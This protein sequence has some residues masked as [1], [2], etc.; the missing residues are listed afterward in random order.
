MIEIEVKAKIDDFDKI[1]QLVQKKCSFIK[2]FNKNDLY[3]CNKE[4]L[5]F[6]LRTLISVDDKQY[7]ITTKEKALENRVEINKETE[8]KID[9]ESQFL[10]FAQLIGFSQTVR[11]IKIGY[12]Y[13]YKNI[14]V[15]LCEVSNLGHFIELEILTDNIINKE[16][17]KQQLF[18]FLDYLCIDKSSIE[19][20]YYIDILKEKGLWI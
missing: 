8:F 14:N 4:G 5:F 10:D 13:K 2:E 9:D 11:K 20:R 15:E 17:Y 12:L 6:R 18:D 16:T 1:K 3:F 19:D 7:I